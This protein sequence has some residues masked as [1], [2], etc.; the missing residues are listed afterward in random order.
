MQ[1][2]HSGIVISSFQ[3]ASGDAVGRRDHP[4]PF[5]AGTLALQHP[6]F[7]ARGID[8]EALVPGLRWGTINLS[9]GRELV[10]ERPDFTAEAVDWTQE[11]K[12]RIAPE[13]FSFVRCCFICPLPDAEGRFG[14]YPGLLYYPHPETKPQTNEHH[15][16]VLEILAQNVPGVAPGV[17]ADIVCRRDAF[18]DR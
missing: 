13:T 6:H 7:R 11:E 2:V 15:Y 5:S 9:L 18:R 10:L 12:T 3:Y 16:D 1:A 17:R 4:S 8:L 14:Y